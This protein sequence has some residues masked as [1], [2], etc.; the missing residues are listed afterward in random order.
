MEPEKTLENPEKAGGKDGKLPGHLKLKTVSIWC[1]LSGSQGYCFIVLLTAQI[2]EFE[3][4]Q[5]FIFT[6]GVAIDFEIGWGFWVRFSLESLG[7]SRV[8]WWGIHGV[9][10]GYKLGN[11]R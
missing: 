1:A 2:I 7:I 10:M 6:N 11:F 4:H 9:T 8:F 5:I 3:I